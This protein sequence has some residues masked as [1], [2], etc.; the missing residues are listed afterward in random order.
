MLR[1]TEFTLRCSNIRKSTCTVRHCCV[2]TGKH[3][4]VETCWHARVSDA[5]M[6]I[7]THTYPHNTEALL[8][9]LEVVMTWMKLL[10]RSIHSQ[11][12]CVFVATC[13]NTRPGGESRVV[14]EGS[15][16]PHLSF[17]AKLYFPFAKYSL[18][19][20]PDSLFFF[21]SLTIILLL[22]LL[23]LSGAF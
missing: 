17:T 7:H 3:R 21:P 15:Y 23:W 5:S 1:S 22:V 2:H 4:F 16:P 9:W 11:T 19:Q 8:C 14:Y 18:T 10:I 6:F 20:I 13:T 12:L